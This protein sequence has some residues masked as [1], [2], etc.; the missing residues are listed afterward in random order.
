MAK[1]TVMVEKVLKIKGKMISHY[2]DSKR[3]GVD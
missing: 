1:L 3:N 2:F